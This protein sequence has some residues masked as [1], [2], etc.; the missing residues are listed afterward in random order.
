MDEAIGGTM[1]DF[2]FFLRL[3]VAGWETAAALDAVA[4]HLGSAT[5]GHR[6]PNY[7]R[8]AG[9]GRAYLMR[10]YGVLRSSSALRTGWRAAAGHPAR[11]WPPPEAIDRRLGFV[12]AMRLRRAIYM[13]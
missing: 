6:S 2:D 8:M 3:R 10:R 13:R 1:D 11:T 4:V 9:F 12:G 7:R 5:Y